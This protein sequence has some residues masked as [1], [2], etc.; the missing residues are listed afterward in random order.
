MGGEMPS[1]VTSHEDQSIFLW[2][3]QAGV[4]GVMETDFPKLE[5]VA[6]DQM[7]QRLHVV[8][9]IGNTLYTYAVDNSEGE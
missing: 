9:E 4:A 1:G 6:F 5:G 3:P 2:S 8:S 7:S